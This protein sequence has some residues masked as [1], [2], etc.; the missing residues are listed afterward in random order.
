MFASIITSHLLSK[1]NNH[2]VFVCISSLLTL[3]FSVHLELVERIIPVLPPRIA[4]HRDFVRSGAFYPDAFYNCRGQYDV[5]EDAH[6]PPFLATGVDLVLERKKKGEDT[7]ELEAFLIGILSHQVSDVSWH[8][9]GLFQGL[10]KAM[11]TSEFNG[12]YDEA[13]SVLD[14]GGDMIQLSRRTDKRKKDAKWQYNIDDIVELVTRAGYPDIPQ[15]S[16]HYCMARG[17]AAY[18]G[19]LQ[20]ADVVHK[21]YSRKSPTMFN[22]LESYF[23]G[24][25]T[26]MHEQVEECLPELIRWMD[27]GVDKKNYYDICP[28]FAGKRN[29]TSYDDTD[30]RIPDIH[31]HQDTDDLYTHPM[32]E[33][34]SQKLIKRDST[35]QFMLE[36]LKDSIPEVKKK[37]TGANS[38]I[39]G[40]H[41]LFKVAS[42]PCNIIPVPEFT[43]KDNNPEA[44]TVAEI[45][46][47]WFGKSLTFWGDKYLVVGSPAE[48]KVHIYDINADLREPML[49]IDSPHP[50]KIWGYLST[51]FGTSVAIWQNDYLAVSSPGISMVDFYNSKGVW[52][53]GLSW[54]NST[55]SYGSPGQKMIGE[56]LLA[57]QDTDTI[58]VGAPRSDFN[59]TTEQSGVVYALPKDI[60]TRAIQNHENIALEL[61]E[62]VLF[63][64]TTPYQHIGI[65]LA[66]TPEGIL[67]GS[68]GTEEV[69]RFTYDSD[70]PRELFKGDSAQ[71]E[72]LNSLRPS[73]FGGSLIAANNDYTVVGAPAGSYSEFPYKSEDQQGVI[74][75]FTKNDKYILGVNE[76]FA[77]FGAKG[78]IHGDYLLVV[79]PHAAGG[80]GMLWKVNMKDRSIEELGAPE[81]SF[82]S[83]FGASVASDGRYL[84]VGMPHLELPSQTRHGGIA[85]IQLH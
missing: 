8:S 23:I 3:L 40:G 22:E 64:G 17:Q 15:S 41:S 47:P 34:R 27:S 61:D 5:A 59:E 75:I 70:L 80:H 79:S 1:Q 12:D 57:S 48:N 44:H 78:V 60:I 6:W 49:T 28:V 82:A 46:Y 77:W 21:T 4:Q 29:R 52:M 66:P 54:E 71:G 2:S 43:E 13:H 19:E 56:T 10:L 65:S 18:T 35:G 25:L 85:L 14:V 58:Y 42:L 53:G 84:A 67:I 63:S 31:Y 69:W 36:I 7:S 33:E 26:D 74:V 76:E 37:L 9:L 24:G 20:V 50:A 68:P 16:I 51:H 83:G 81:G 32:D 11:A 38:I 39:N 55:V 73:R 62:N 45:F 30:D 72:K